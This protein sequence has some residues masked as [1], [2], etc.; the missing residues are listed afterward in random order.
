MAGEV[1]DVVVAA[2]QAREEVRP[3]RVAA[4]QHVHRDFEL[5]VVAGQRGD[6][7]D[8]TL[9]R[10]EIGRGVRDCEDTRLGIFLE[11]VAAGAGPGPGAYDTAERVFQCQ[12]ITIP[13]HQLPRQVERGLV[14]VKQQRGRPAVGQVSRTGVAQECLPQFAAQ[15]VH[16]RKRRFRRPAP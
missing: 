6:G 4:G 16:F 9:G 8:L 13:G 15:L 14:H 10:G 12:R 3:G 7:R 11:R 2:G 1:D 5:A